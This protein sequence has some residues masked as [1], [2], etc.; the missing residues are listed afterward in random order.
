MR[1]QYPDGGVS[2]ERSIDSILEVLSH[3]QR[4][5][6]LRYCSQVPKNKVPMQ[7]LIVH[8]KEVEAERTGEEP[9]TSHLESVL[10][11]VH[12]PK[13]SEAGLIEYDVENQYVEYIPDEQ[14][15]T[16]LRHI[17]SIEDEW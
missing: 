12:G 8:L 15:E 13:L 14:V 17:Q 3:Y 1:R 11:H 10:I 5:E 6:I 16:A 7:Q 2:G 9:G 4:R